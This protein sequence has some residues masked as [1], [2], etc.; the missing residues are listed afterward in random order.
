MHRR[1]R[2]RHYQVSCLYCNTQQ[3]AGSSRFRTCDSWAS[4][5][6][7]ARNMTSENGEMLLRM[8]S[9][10]G[11]RCIELTSTR[12]R[13]PWEP[14]RQYGTYDGL[15]TEQDPRWRAVVARDKSA[16]GT[17]YYSVKTT[18][19]YCRPSCAARLANPKNVSF[20]LTR[21]EAERAGLPPLQAVQAGP[22]GRPAHARHGRDP[23][24]GQ[25]SPHMVRCW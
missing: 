16:D 18:G 17:F 3:C 14:L 2:V 4:G 9:I 11:G 25:R 1:Y 8:A 13:Q 15:I 12:R 22:E 19:V 10:I 6:T 20:H 7:V 24:R 5:A 23:I 21:E